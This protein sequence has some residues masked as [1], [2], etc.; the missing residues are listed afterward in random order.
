MSAWM[1]IRGTALAF[2]CALGLAASACRPPGPRA[3]EL[4]EDQCAYCRMEVTDARFAAEAI[5][6]TGRINVFD[7]VE[8][9][10]GYART[11]E[12]G[13]VRGFWVTDAEQP[14]TFV[15]AAAAG[16]L[17]GS[18]LRAPMGRTVAFASPDA[19]RAAQARYGGTVT[20]WNSVLADTTAGAHGAH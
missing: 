10:A 20:T 3:V 15:D 18:S 14:G 16:F 8:C 19:A 2:A 13:A 1:A 11:A 17:V 12:P 9:L 5:T 4:N 7:S 6:R